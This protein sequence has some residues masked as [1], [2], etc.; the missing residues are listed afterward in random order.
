MKDIDAT[1]PHLA[2]QMAVLRDGLQGL[3]SYA[4]WRLILLV[5][6]ILAAAVMYRLVTWR[7]LAA[8]THPVVAGGATKRIAEHHRTSRGTPA[9]GQGG[10]VDS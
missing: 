4:L 5:M 3:I 10:G 6:A 1:S 9:T 8:A 2:G 7:L